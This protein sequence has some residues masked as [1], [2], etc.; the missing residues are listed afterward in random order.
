MKAESVMV[1]L[2]KAFSVFTHPSDASLETLCD[3][4]ASVEN[5]SLVIS[6]NVEIRL[7]VKRLSATAGLDLVDLRLVVDLQVSEA[8]T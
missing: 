5:V 2:K 3:S 6:T 4:N 8:S 1:T 7:Q